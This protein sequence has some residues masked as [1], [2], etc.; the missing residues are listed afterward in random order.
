MH[1]LLQYKLLIQPYVQSSLTVTGDH[2]VTLA[3]PMDYID[4]MGHAPSC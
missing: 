1:L 3:M 4:G 2:F